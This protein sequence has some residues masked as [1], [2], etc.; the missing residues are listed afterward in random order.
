MDKSLYDAEVNAIKSQIKDIY[1]SDEIPWVVGYSGGKD[2]TAVTQLVW[3]ALSELERDQLHKPVYII[4]TDTLV[5]NPVVSSWVKNSLKKIEKKSLEDRLPIYPN[6]LTPKVNNTFW[7]NV[8]GR[9]YPAPR[10]KFRW[11]TDRLKIKPADEFINSV[12]KQNGQAIMILGT[13]KA[14]SVS[15]SKIIN[16]KEAKSVRDHLTLSDT[17][18]NAFIYAPIVEW[19][20]DDVWV[21]LM[22]E[23]N[24]WG[25]NNKDLLTMY[26]GATADGECPLV[27]DTTTPSCGNSRFGCWVCTLVSKDKSM[28]AMVQNDTENE[29]MAPLLKL[30]NELDQPDREIRDFRRM[31]GNVTLFSSNDDDP[32]RPINVPGPYTQNARAVWLRKLLT[33]EHNLQTSDNTPENV[34]DIELISLAEL[35]EIRKIWVLEKH[36]IEDI[37]PEIYK[38]VKGSDFPGKS[39]NENQPFMSEDLSL[40]KDLCEGDDMNFELVRGLLDIENKQQNKNRRSN[41]FKEIENIF[42]KTFYEDAED[43]ISRA[44]G[45]QKM[46]TIIDK[47]KNGE[48][49]ILETLEEVRN[50]IN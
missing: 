30:R 43:A 44:K 8:I 31:G 5:E 40:L 11:C 42:N 12:V 38:E 34:R 9:G 47:Q 13:R 35:D 49:N 50:N 3:T 6:L 24:P 37:L 23:E 15:R 2:S 28:S 18:P 27:V 17:L 10:Q 21:Y 19:S 46:A 4:S 25:N 48:L 1:L 45:I 32:D 16:E 36:E 41:L 7:V 29:W 14:E 22:Q 26:Q 39:I 33:I 20:N